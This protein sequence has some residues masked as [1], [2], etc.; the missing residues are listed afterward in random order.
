M[1][2]I[3]KAIERARQERQHLSLQAQPPRAND[4]PANGASP[5]G[6]PTNGAPTNGATSRVPAATA[7]PAA[8][9]PAAR[10]E[11]IDRHHLQA[12]RV[13]AHEAAA[14][15]SSHYD[16]LRTQVLQRMDAA[17]CQTLAVTSP[18]SACGKTLT[19][20]NLALSMARQSEQTVL[21]VDLDLR[22]P[23][24]GRYLGLTPAAGIHD[25][26]SGK[27]SGADAMLVP[28]VCGHRLAVI[29]TPHPVPSPTEHLVS[30]AMRATLARLKADHGRRIIIFDLPPMLSSDDFLAFLPQVDC[31]LLVASSGESTVQDIAECERLID[32]DKFL[33]CVLNKVTETEDAYHYYG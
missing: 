26:I 31:A 11:P 12:M 5:N 13:V 16:M 30:S 20:I 18:R 10:I 7:A 3:K 4:A 23:Q 32:P 14:V 22:K 8:P 24:V 6:A 27:C 21:L 29:A 15:H 33:G 2:H 19:A 25:V 9:L 28:D 1:E 17:S